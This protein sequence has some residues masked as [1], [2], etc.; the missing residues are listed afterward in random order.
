MSIFKPT[1]PQLQRGHPLAR[2]LVGA[3][4]FTEGS[5]PTAHDSSGYGNQGALTG[6]PTW[7]G[8]RAGSALSFNGTTNYVSIKRTI[9]DDFTIS[10]WFSTFSSA[11]S[12]GHWYL[13][14]SLVDGEMS[15]STQNDFGTS[16]NQGKANFG[17]GNPDTTIASAATYND[18]SWHLLTATRVKASG[19]M[20]LYVD[21]VVVGT[22]TS[23]TNSLTTPTSIEFGR[24]PSNYGPA[25]YPGIIDSVHIYNRA[26][27]ATEA[28]LMYTLAGA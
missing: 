15:G 24:P 6:P 14:K 25:Y 17:C 19:A 4:A 11:G 2:G 16:V 21:G 13:G 27:S 1:I 22:A 7:V 9:S 8:G 20:A 5:G 3:W 18:G 28:A 23:N 10:V 26:L 12:G